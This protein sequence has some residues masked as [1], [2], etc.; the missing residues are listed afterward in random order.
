MEEILRRLARRAAD[1]HCMNEAGMNEAGMNE[2]G[3]NEAG[4][5]IDQL[6][7]KL[8]CEWPHLRHARQSIETREML[9]QT[10][11]PF[12]SE[13]LSFVRCS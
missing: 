5:K 9:K 2:A 11:A 3:M 1:L 12:D 6:A 13:D 8:G 4:S 10:L 7:A